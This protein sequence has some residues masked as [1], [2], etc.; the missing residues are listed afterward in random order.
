MKQRYTLVALLGLCC[1]ACMAQNPVTNGG[2]EILDAQGRP[3]DWQLLGETVAVTTD[4]HSGKFALR[5]ERGSGRDVPP[6]IGLN[7]NWSPDS[8]QQGKMLAERKGGILFWYKLVSTSPG[9][10]VSVQVIPMSARPFEDTGS[11]RAIYQ[12]PH[13]HAGDGRWHQGK[14][15]YDFTDNPKVKW[16]HV[17]VRLTGGPAVLIVDDMEYVERVGAVLQFEKMHF[18]PDKSAP[19]KAGMFTFSVTNAGDT[20]SQP[21]QVAVRAPDGWRVQPLRVPD[22]RSIAP[23]DG[24]TYR[25]RVQGVLKPSTLRLTATDGRETTEETFRLAPSVELESVLMK[26][27]MA[28]P[29]GTVEIVATVRNRGTAIA[30]GVELRCTLPMSGAP[31]VFLSGNAQKVPPI[32]PGGKAVVRRKMRAGSQPGE[33]Q[34]D[35]TLRAPETLPQSARS[36]LIITDALKRPAQPVVGTLW[37][38]RGSDRTIGELRVGNRV[39]ARMPHL[40]SVVVKLPDGSVQRL[41]PRYLPPVRRCPRSPYMFNGGARDRAGARWT[42][43]LTVQPVD[44]HTLRMEYACVPDKPRDVLAFEGPILLVGDGSTADAKEEALLPGLEWLTADEVSSSDLDIAKD[45][46][47]RMRFVPHPHKVT[48]PAMGVKTPAAVVGL[49]WNVH[50]RWGKGQQMPQPVFAVPDRLKGTATHRLGL[51]APNVPAGLGENRLTAEKPFRVTP[52]GYLRLSALMVV[53]PQARDALSVVDTWFARFPPDPPLP[54][55]QGSDLEQI[56][57]S[58]KAYTD[59]LWVSDE[60]GWLPFQGGPAIWSRPAFRADYVYDLLKALIILPGHPESP[61]WRALVDKT[62]SRIGTPQAEDMQFEYG[63]V[64]NTLSFLRTRA[65]ELMQSQNPDGS[66]GFDADRR[67]QG[68]FKGY[69]YHQLGH[70]DAVELGTCARNAYEI[71]RYARLSGSEEAYR[72]GAKTL[73]FMRRFT[74]P[75]AAQVWEVPVHTPDILAAADAV[76]AYIEGYWFS[77]DRRW[78]AEARRWARAGLPFVYVWNAPGKP[79]MR[80][81]S[82]PVFGASLY[83]VSWF[84]NIVQWNGLRYAYA[85]L[86]LCEADKNAPPLW[87]RIAL[88]ITRCAMYQQSTSGKNLALWPDSYHTI[89]DTRAAWDFAPRL[90]LKNVYHFLEREE[91]PRTVRLPNG[92]RVSSRAVK[93]QVSEAGDTLRVTL[94]HPKGE[95]G[96]VLISGV[97]R[98][99]EVLLQAQPLHEVERWTPEARRQNG[100]RYSQAHRALII[101]LATDAEVTVEIHG[102]RRANLPAFPRPITDLRFEFAEDTEG[103]EP[104]NDLEPLHLR[105]GVLLARSIGSDPYMIRPLCRFDG[106]S[107][108]RIRIRLR[109]SGGRGGQF[110][111]ATASSPGFD[112]TKVVQ[113]ELPLDGEWHE[114]VIPV[115]EHPL[116]RGQT[117]TAIRLDPGSAPDTVVEIDWI[118]G[119]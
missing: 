86:K 116:W 47:D 38:R 33:W 112:E 85:L 49:L 30:E 60:Q 72:A 32:A 59:S 37:I 44:S 83:T 61:K 40:G 92:I 43:T 69:D 6:E 96:S 66:W 21:V 98:P 41:F 56:A 28:A 2:F 50:D 25:W 45:H 109:G 70:P 78:M 88:G 5:F 27:A 103:W 29:G 113:F 74:V 8:G 94:H 53:N 7:R 1:L 35:C 26:P 111:W 10:S 58:M 46:P 89:H 81:G 76:D 101:H 31:L 67:D 9:A 63:D 18:Y 91:E 97:S 34:V 117:I 87:R 39:V 108:Q 71:L 24:L 102:V 62:L 93:M 52:D 65:Q 118:R 114:V 12:I 4:A 99:V 55:P 115:G 119:E 110:Y 82:I 17:G 15:V 3:V 13:Q 73:E 80:Y 64:E 19:D 100:W 14:L 79:W 54:A 51:I 68:V 95:G 107:V 16:V 11:P 84:G 23:G 22:T 105:N 77:G 106:S 36:T 75:R 57:W 48:I 42:F 90:I 104:A 20:P